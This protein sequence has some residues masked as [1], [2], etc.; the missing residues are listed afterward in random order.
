MF[1]C[2]KPNGCYYYWTGQLT[3]K[4]QDADGIQHK[5]PII[6]DGRNVQHD[7][8]RFIRVSQETNRLMK[9]DGLSHALARIQALKN[10]LSNQNSKETSTKD[11]LV[12]TA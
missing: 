5:R 4:W 2:L 3:E 10:V 7:H 6:V 11:G 1:H 12:P 8:E 9:K